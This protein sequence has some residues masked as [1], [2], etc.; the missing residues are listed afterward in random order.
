MKKLCYLA[1]FLLVISGCAL[2]ESDYL[3]Q[4]SPAELNQVMQNED[5][6]LLDVHTPE[7]Q[8]IQGNDLFVPYDQIENFKDKL[9]KDKNAA[10]Y[11]Y[12]KSGG[13]AVSAAKSLHEL[14]YSNLYNLTGG[15]DAWRKAGLGFQN[16]Q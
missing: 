8:H 6:F 3:K 5:I 10:L 14:G 12:C 7:Q 9:P 1:A 15:A 4:I 2:Q 11:L 16:G 13:M